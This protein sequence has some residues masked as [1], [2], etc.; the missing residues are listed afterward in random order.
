MSEEN[1]AIIS[2]IRDYFADCP[3]LDEFAE[4][5]VNYLAD[6][7]KAYSI[8]EN[9][10]YDPVIQ[11]FMCGAEMQVLFMLDIR[12][13]WNEDIQNNVENSKLFENIRKWLKDNKEKRI[14]PGILGCYD[15]GA[16]TSGYIFATNANEAIYRIQCYANYS[17]F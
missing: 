3:Y 4:L 12:L 17:E 13:I 14:F 6:K 11:R 8:T 1:E 7:T 16:T 15:I 9:A 2:K 10:G 5:N